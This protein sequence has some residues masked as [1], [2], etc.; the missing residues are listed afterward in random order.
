[1][2]RGYT[3]FGS[4]TV[5]SGS[6]PFGCAPFEA[7]GDAPASDEPFEL[8]DA[9]VADLQ[10]GMESGRAIAYSYEQATQHRKPP[11]LLPTLG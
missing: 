4:A 9:T 5:L 7:P 2:N 10:A 6:A 3:A 8:H 1:M 11:E